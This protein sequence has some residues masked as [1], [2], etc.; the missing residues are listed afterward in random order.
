ME[1]VLN[2]RSARDHMEKNIPR[3]KEKTL[4]MEGTDDQSAYGRYQTAGVFDPRMPKQL[5]KPRSIFSGC[6][7]EPSILNGKEFAEKRREF[8]T[9]F[10]VE[11]KRESWELFYWNML[12]MG[13]MKVSS[14]KRILR[15]LDKQY[16][17]LFKEQITGLEEDFAEKQRFFNSNLLYLVAATDGNE[18]TLGHSQLVA[19][20]CILLT[21]ALGI[22]D[23]SFLVNIERGALLHDIG[24][25]GIP[26]SILRKAGPLTKKEK[27]I[28]QQHPILGYEMIEEF[29]FLK[30][31]ALVVLFHHER[32][33]GCGYPYGLAGEEIPLEA[34]IFA[35]ADTLDAITSDRPYSRGK[36]FPEA[37]REIEKSQGSQF[38]PQLADVFLSIP[39]E[40]WQRIK[41]KTQISLPSLTIH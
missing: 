36:S 27:E 39:V 2:K 26:E 41:A 16:E 15:R 30:R 38:D 5:N 23:K 33:D 17:K 9:S 35:L 21:K 20:Y 29:D 19:S 13:A 7:Q 28:T 10:V 6:H 14:A 40:K 18:D 22:E 4:T 37:Y 24:K 3:E 32:Y 11:G 25:I 8:M 31:A 34:R 12:T 1:A